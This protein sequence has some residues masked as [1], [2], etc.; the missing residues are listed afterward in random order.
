MGILNIIPATSDSSHNASSIDL[1]LIEEQ[2]LEV[3]LRA[4][5]A[6]DPFT[7]AHCRR[8]GSDSEAFAKFLGLNEDTQRIC[9]FSGSLHD[10]GKINLPDTILHKPA[11]LSDFEFRRM[12]GHAALGEHILKPAFS[13]PTFQSSL[14][15]IRHHHERI[16]GR[17]YPDALHGTN[18]PYISRL[19]CI[20]DAFDA[21]T[22]DRPYHIPRSRDEAIGEILR[23][24]DTQFD[25]ELS[26][27]Y[28]KFKDVQ[29]SLLP[30]EEKK[31]A[32][33]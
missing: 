31:K 17:G 19:L 4:L 9:L 18:I 7:A 23:C 5:E 21:M 2:M 33:A 8:V 6:H 28:L 20:T 25:L 27:S 32:A 24:S 1:K 3:V 29:F 10:L 14:S 15:P 26:F 11:K 12:K 30:H 16:D 22:E 13:L